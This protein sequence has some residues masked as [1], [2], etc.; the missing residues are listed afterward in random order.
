MKQ[1]CPVRS[2]CSF[3]HEHKKEAVYLKKKKIKN[4][5]NQWMKA[6][7][8]WLKCLLHNHTV[9]L[10]KKKKKK[11]NK[12]NKNNGRNV[13]CIH[14]TS[15]N[16]QRGKQKVKTTAGVREGDTVFICRSFAVCRQRTEERGPRWV[17]R[18]DT[19]R[20]TRPWGLSAGRTTWIHCVSTTNW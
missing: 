3:S 19:T 17:T 20:G 2:V 18:S 8:F 15:Q 5:K 16:C 4:F 6:S 1:W 12:Q 13:S 11:S 7:L 9:H 10:K 14:V